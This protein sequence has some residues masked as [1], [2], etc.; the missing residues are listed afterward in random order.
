MIPKKLVR[1]KQ[2]DM[3]QAA[4]VKE[5]LLRSL[6]HV[7]LWLEGQD[8]DAIVVH[9]GLLVR[10]LV[11]KR[12]ELVQRVVILETEVQPSASDCLDRVVSA[13]VHAACGAEER[14]ASFHG[15]QRSGLACLVDSYAQRELDSCFQWAKR[16]QGEDLVKIPAHGNDRFTLL[17]PEASA[18]LCQER[19]TSSDTIFLLQDML[20]Q[21]EGKERCYRFSYINWDVEEQTAKATE[22]TIQRL[23]RVR[24]AWKEDEDLAVAV[25]YPGHFFLL[26]REG[27]Q[28]TDCNTLPGLGKEA[29]DAIVGGGT[30][31]PP[32]MAQLGV[33]Q[34]SGTA[35]GVYSCLFLL[36][37]ALGMEDMGDVLVPFLNKRGRHDTAAMR[38]WLFRSC[39]V[40]RVDLGPWT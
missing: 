28:W 21:L 40:G 10:G 38:R 19:F 32:E 7:S 14:M 22:D 16:S 36:A 15:V 29:A 4:L 30:K 37:F 3:T 9:A 35:C 25:G 23:L 8:G 13:L 18:R 2:G 5:H 31:G 17:T 6:P 39:A 20:G 33:R 12:P 34:A 27:G 26:V 1:T 11:T 24:Y